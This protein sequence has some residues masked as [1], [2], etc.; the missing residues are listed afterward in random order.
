[1]HW[2]GRTR[3]WA[4]A[5]VALLAAGVL[6][7]VA[8]PRDDAPAPRLAAGRGNAASSTTTLPQVE[9]AVT[10]PDPTTTPIPPPTTVTAVPMTRV[11]RPPTATA[12]PTTAAASGTA[13]PGVGVVVTVPSRGIY[14][15]DLATGT[16]VRLAE[17]TP[18][19]VAG[20]RLLL[21]SG[22]TV[23]A[24]PV[25]GGERRDLY[26]LSGG[27]RIDWLEA[28]PDATAVVKLSTPMRGPDGRETGAQIVQP[29]I[30]PDGQV[31]VADL[32]GA[33]FEWSADGRTL[34]NFNYQG[35]RGYRPTGEVA[36]GPIASPESIMMSLRVSSDAAAVTGQFNSHVV[37]LL[38]VATGQWS[39]TGVWRDVSFGP[40]GRL[41]GQP[42]P[43][44][45]WDGRRPLGIVIWSPQ[46]GS[47]TSLAPSGSEPV[48]APTG[49]HAVILDAPLVGKNDGSSYS[50]R[51]RAIDGSPRFTLSA[52]GLLFGRDTNAHNAGPGIA[53]PQWTADGRYL[54]VAAT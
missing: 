48:W 36:W 2:G 26:T 50:L 25:T 53:G 27:E 28:A 42:A 9:V 30:A 46:D 24:V 38:D 17:V 52:P 13:A 22:T 43:P 8:Y 47:Q 51:V 16:L 21:T 6:A 31:R 20:D 37:R 49:E 35:F 10:A 19:D 29:L 5:S 14:S 3:F 45:G 34:V 4:V 39:E 15:F 1:V 32:S 7:A 54:V 40:G 44:P 33:E 11:A 23:S 12:P 18:F 41:L